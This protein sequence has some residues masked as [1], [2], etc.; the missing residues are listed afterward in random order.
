MPYSTNVTLLDTEGGASTTADVTAR[1]W[2]SWSVVGT[3][4]GSGNMQQE[5]GSTMGLVKK[6]LSAPLLVDFPGPTNFAYASRSV[7]LSVQDTPRVANDTGWLFRSGAFPDDLPAEAVE[8]VTATRRFTNAELTA[9]LPPLPITADPGTTTI[10]TAVTLTLVNDAIDIAATGTT[11]AT[12]T[13]LAFTAMGQIVLSPSSDVRAAETESL[14][15]G[16]RNMSVTFAPGTNV[17]ASIIA[18]VLNAFSGFV[19]TRMRPQIQQ[20]LEK[21]LNVE[22]A[23]GIGRALQTGDT[24]P[25]GVVLSVRSTNVTPDPGGVLEIRGALGAFGGVFSKLPPIQ[26]TPGSGGKPCF[27][28]TAVH[29]ADSP[30]VRLL[31]SFRDDDLKKFFAGRKFVSFYETVSP[32]IANYIVDKPHWKAIARALVV[33]PGAQIA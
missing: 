16:P 29:G 14:N 23:K 25:P 20:A 2:M 6:D 8:I 15:V 24:L 19:L 11:M 3:G 22:I 28:A 9:M 10:I 17:I 4:T 5:Q 26:I 27:I 13:L 7:A 1:V 32:P 30:E 31:R 18:S 33:R 12:G 21:A